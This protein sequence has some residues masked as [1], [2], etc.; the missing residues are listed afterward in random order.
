[1]MGSEVV[2][3]YSAPRL[4]G[5]SLSISEPTCDSRGTG[6][7]RALES[8]RTKVQ[9]EGP[10]KTKGS[11]IKAPLASDSPS[12]AAN[13]N[14]AVRREKPWGW[15]VMERKRIRSESEMGRVSVVTGPAR[16]GGSVYIFS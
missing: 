14:R 3:V 2:E 9:R 7:E 6:Q 11:P 8:Q 1:M 4:S 10:K 13:D 5:A 15:P 12:G 16:A